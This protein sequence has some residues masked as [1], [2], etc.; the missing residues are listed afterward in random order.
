MLKH[1]NNID[2]ILNHFV[3]NISAAVEFEYEYDD[4]DGQ[5]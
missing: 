5:E 1:F 4:D 2:R 3:Y